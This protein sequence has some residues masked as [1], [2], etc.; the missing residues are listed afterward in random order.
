MLIF[1]RVGATMCVDGFSLEHNSP[2]CFRA[3]MTD[4]PEPLF[5]NRTENG[6]IERW[7]H[8]LPGIFR[9]IDTTRNQK[10]NRLPA[11]SASFRHFRH[12][13]WR[14]STAL[15]PDIAL[16]NHVSHVA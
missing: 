3:T 7:R 11:F 1:W 13:P 4:R 6:Q 12:G 5:P 9:G 8:I 16:E 10:L 14:H 2:G 15:S